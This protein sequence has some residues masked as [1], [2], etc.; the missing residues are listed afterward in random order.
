MRF[1]TALATTVVLGLALAAPSLA[2]DG[3]GLRPPVPG[4]PEIVVPDVQPISSLEAGFV[5]LSD[6]VWLE[7]SPIVT[8]QDEPGLVGGSVPALGPGVDDPVIEENSTP[9]VVSAMLEPDI[10]PAVDLV[11]DTPHST[12]DELLAPTVDT[13]VSA[14]VLSPGD[15]AI[16]QAEDFAG[17]AAPS[18]ANATVSP[19]T[20]EPASAAEPPSG[21]RPHGGQGTSNSGQEP[22]LSEIDSPRYHDT[23]SQY[24]SNGQPPQDA[25]HWIWSLTL[26]CAGNVTSISSQIG[27]QTSLTWYWDWVWDWACGSTSSNTSGTTSSGSSTN[28][29]SNSDTGNTNVSVQVRSPGETGSVTVPA[30][31]TEG[32]EATGAA[33]PS[34]LWTWSWTFTFCGETT[35]LSTQLDSQTPLSWTWNWMWNWTCDT[36]AGAP[37]EV[38]DATPSGADAAPVLP[39]SPVIPAL[40]GPPASAQGQVFLV[41]VPLTE[42]PPLS[43]LP[44]VPSVEVEVAVLVE[45]GTPLLALPEFPLP[46]PGVPGVDVS[47]VIVPVETSRTPARGADM[48]PEGGHEAPGHRGTRSSTPPLTTT[49]I[50]RQR[51][52]G[53]PSAPSSK[54]TARPPS[55]QSAPPRRAPGP[56]LPFGQPGSS[57][58]AGSG[59]FGGRVPSAPVAAVAALIA[60]F[61]LAAPYVGRRIRVVR[62]L[63]PRSTYR[64]SIDHPG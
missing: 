13:N 18:H 1:P 20:A 3:E 49:P 19:Q 21:T 58:T 2:S 22:S 34:G 54:P 38:G 50:A 42:W 27:S 10:R 12:S 43:E 48:T 7:E 29:L 59:T 45:P 30:G 51:P 47:V 56:F 40:P 63:S 36:P 44:V 15:G 5:L 11:T 52:E 37:L 28:F 39:L 25:W 32:A 53:S 57:E 62:E 6:E 60:F 61:I 64:S 55:A 9:E 24:Q 33:P 46:S 17:A 16:R 8:G 41:D 35:S 14:P 26:D 31:A 4:V 23:N